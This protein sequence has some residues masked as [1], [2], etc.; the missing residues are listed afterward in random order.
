VVFYARQF[1]WIVRFPGNDGVLGSTDYRLITEKNPTGLITQKNIEQSLAALNSDIDL[2][3]KTP[4]GIYGD[5][6]EKQ[7]KIQQKDAIEKL[8]GQ[9]SPEK[10]NAGKDDV[11]VVDELHLPVNHPIKAS[12]QSQD[13][14]HGA[15][16]PHFRTSM[17]CVPGITNHLWLRIDYTTA[18][19]RQKIH[20]PGFDYFLICNNI[21]G[22]GHFS[23][24]MK[25]VVEPMEDFNKWLMTLPM[26]SSPA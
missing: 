21:C 4:T 17:Y 8:R 5:E 12:F 22:T 24:K 15:Y 26:Q 23:M 1:S 3:N 2:I 10:L 11:W 7:K 14:I 13:V 20:D 19:M 18:Q 16:F 6:K 9:I 25:I